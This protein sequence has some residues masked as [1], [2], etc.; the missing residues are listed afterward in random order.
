[1]TNDLAK[2]LQEQI[3][4]DINIQELFEE[5]KTKEHGDVAFPCFQLAKILKKSP[6]QIAQDLQDQIKDKLPTHYEKVEAVGPYLNFF[7][8]NF[9]EAQDI[10]EALQDNSLFTYKTN[11]PQKILIEYPSPNT[12]KALH[13]GHTRNMLLGT[14]LCNILEEAG[15]QIIKT[16]LNNDRGIAVCK[17]MLAYKLWGEN[18]TPQD[19]DMKP[20]QFVSYWYVVYGEKVKQNSDLDNQAQAMLQQWEAGDSETL[21]LWQYLLDWVYEGYHQTYQNYH[22]PQ[23]DKEFYESQIYD[24]GK[25]I[26]QNA[27]NNKVKGFGQEQ[28]GAVYVN[29]EDSGYGTKYLL[30]GDGTTLYMTQDIYLA[31]LKEELFKA[32]KY[33]F[34]VGQE[35]EYHF[36]VLFELLDRLD[37]AK[38]QNNYHFAYGYVYDEKG[39]KFSSRLG[40]TISADDILEQSIQKAKQNLQTK[41]LTKNLNEKETQRRANIIGFG[42]L[43]F[44][45][46][47]TNP[48][49]SINFSIDNALSFEGETGPYIQYTY[50]RI[51]SLLKKGKYNAHSQEEWLV[52]TLT[53]KE[54]EHIKLLKKY[55]E[56]LQEAVENYKISSIAQFGIK[57]SQSFNDLYQEV[58]F[59]KVEDEV[60]K[61]SRLTL[62][63]Y[64]GELLK[65]L[66]SLYSIEL[67]DEM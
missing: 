53:Q 28:D 41:E 18:K 15:H 42:A 37:I 43:A 56:T 19:M 9:K 65:K 49:S 26:V 23:F 50:A 13:I 2:L 4:E 30:R 57:V 14:A 55:Q 25:E 58:S 31:S 59:T 34:V 24:K 29:L 3:G 38:T 66:M 36:N 21:K 40:N 20:D 1:M 5:P 32:D 35:Q 61:Q 47:K 63:Y 64:T 16:N 44:T 7:L 62:A 33:V 22:L 27:L 45:F 8:D 6:Q 67:L 46:L 12:N 48:L 10:A 51:Q 52:K 17:A 11:N 54:L 60:T 39:Q